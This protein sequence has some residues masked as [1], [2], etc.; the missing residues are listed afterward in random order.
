MGKRLFWLAVG[1]GVT[2]VV[3]LKG[4]ELYE[5]FTPKGVVEQIERTRSGL[6]DWAGEFLATM[7]E[8]MDEREEELRDALGLD[9]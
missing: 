6:F 2:A 4:R 5:R 3:V 7:G 1:V 9:E 8:A